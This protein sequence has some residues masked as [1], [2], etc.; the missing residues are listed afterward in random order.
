[1]NGNPAVYF[2]GPNNSLDEYWLG[3]GGWSL[4]QVTTS[5][6]FSG[7]GA[8]Q[9]TNSTLPSVYYQGANSTLMEGWVAG[10]SWVTAA[11]GTNLPVGVGGTPSVTTN[12]DGNPSVFFN[13]P[14]NPGGTA[15]AGG[16]VDASI[17]QY[18]LGGGGWSLFQVR[19]NG[20][21]SEIGA[22]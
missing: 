3:S 11:I 9:Q 10:G 7:P 17:Y 15:S 21:Y 12:P 2:Q 6:V 14:N 16:A 19:P 8:I 20:A 1:V 5:G 18:W 4:Y 13:G 22:Y